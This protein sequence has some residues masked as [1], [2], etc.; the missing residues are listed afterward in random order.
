M[1][2]KRHS[3]KN[4]LATKLRQLAEWLAP[5][6]VRNYVEEDPLDRARVLKQEADRNRMAW[7]DRKFV[8]NYMLDKLRIEYP[9]LTKSRLTAIIEDACD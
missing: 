9:R 1:A 7:Q 8:H 6:P 2:T 5:T 3:V 4:Y